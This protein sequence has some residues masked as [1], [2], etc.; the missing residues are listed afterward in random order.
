MHAQGAPSP[1]FHSGLLLRAA[2]PFDFNADVTL[3]GSGSS[4]PEGGN[5]TYRWSWTVSAE[6]YN[7]QGV[8]SE[9]ERP[10]I[11]LPVGV[12]TITL[13]VT[14]DAD[15]PLTSDPDTVEITVSLPQT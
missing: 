15:I 5:L 13:V 14:D 1:H 12:H 11:T 3:D 6:E 10:T 9:Y 4:D 7:I 8:G 2:I